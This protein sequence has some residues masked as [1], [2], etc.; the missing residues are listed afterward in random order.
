MCLS[1]GS[2]ELCAAH[3][4]TQSLTL[5]HTRCSHTHTPVPVCLENQGGRLREEMQGTTTR[6]G[7]GFFA[8][9]LSPSLALHECSDSRSS[10]AFLLLLQPLLIASKLSVC[11][12]CCIRLLSRLTVCLLFLAFHFCFSCL[13]WSRCAASL[14]H[15]SSLSPRLASLDRLITS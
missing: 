9:D 8:A 13:L 11:V 1:R 6:R 4:L 2:E 14:A 10:F 3:S 5:A 15:P 12:L 7:G